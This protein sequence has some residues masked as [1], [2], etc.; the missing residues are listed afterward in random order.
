M[1]TQP[2]DSYRTPAVGEALTIKGVKVVV[3]RSTSVCD[4][5]AFEREGTC[6]WRHAAK[7]NCVGI[8][9]MAEIEYLKKQM[10]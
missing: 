2:L 8:V 4:G 9:F 1:T 10:R 3:Q 5:C 6:R 7:L